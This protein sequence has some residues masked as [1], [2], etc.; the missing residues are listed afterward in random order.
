MINTQEQHQE[1][2]PGIFTF[3]FEQVKYNKPISALLNFEENLFAKVV[4]AI[5][6]LL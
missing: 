4:V 2:C 6:I 1:T 3:G 5:V